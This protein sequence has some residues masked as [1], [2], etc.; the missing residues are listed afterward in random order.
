MQYALLVYETETDRERRR[1]GGAAQRE[2][3][4]AYAAFTRALVDAGLLRGGEA[5]ALPDVAT[6]VTAHD[7]GPPRVQD[8][9]YADTKEQLGGFFVIEVAHLDEA[10]RWAARCPA[11]RTGR[12]EVRPVVRPPRRAE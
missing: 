7:D 11:A 6:T 5:L 1:V 8:G 10:L 9:P 2:V 3:D 4:D 12:V